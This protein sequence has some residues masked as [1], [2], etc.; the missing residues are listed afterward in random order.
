MAWHKVQYNTTQSSPNQSNPLQCNAG[1]VQ[2]NAIQL[3]VIQYSTMQ[4]NAT[5]LNASLYRTVPY[6]YL[7]KVVDVGSGC[8]GLLLKTHDYLQS[9][10]N[11][12]H[13]YYI[14]SLKQKMKRNTKID[15]E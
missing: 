14:K 8:Q 11:Y 1:A 2:C 15:L 4:C 3:N 7:F 5:Q 13:Y 6:R 10:H 12:L 9:K